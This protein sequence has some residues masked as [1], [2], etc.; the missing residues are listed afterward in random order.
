M[1]SGH[2]GNGK[3]R[4]PKNR[5]ILSLSEIT[6]FADLGLSLETPQDAPAGDFVVTYFA[7]L[8]WR[9]FSG[10]KRPLLDYV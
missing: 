5:L 10:S 2:T 9:A 8:N 1:A 6:A 7:R 4:C 3:E